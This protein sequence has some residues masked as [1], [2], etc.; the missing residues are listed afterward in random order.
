MFLLLVYNTKKQNPGTP[1]VASH[2]WYK[3]HVSP[4]RQRAVRRLLFTVWQEFFFDEYDYVGRLN[5][6]VSSP[7]SL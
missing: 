7:F 6:D 3:I 5:L 1:T 4:T 2:T